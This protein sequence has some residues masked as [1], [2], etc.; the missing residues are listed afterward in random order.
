MI[1]FLRKRV[2]LGRKGALVLAC[3]VVAACSQDVRRHGYVPPPEDLAKIEVGKSTRDSVV[4]TVGAP[5]SVDLR[6]DR[7]FYYIQTTTRK[8]GARAQSAVG[9][10]LVVINFDARGVVSNVQ[11]IELEGDKIVSFERR[12]TD[13]GANNNTFLRQLLGNLTNFSPGAAT[14]S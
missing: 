2:E 8:Y 13:A 6:D 3:V 14:G 9:H 5:S 11:E 4:E 1:G 10:R 7:G 12:V